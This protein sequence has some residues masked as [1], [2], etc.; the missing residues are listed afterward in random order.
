MLSGFSVTT[1]GWRSL[2]GACVSC[3][4]PFMLPG[5]LHLHCL[6][7]LSLENFDLVCDWSLVMYRGCVEFIGSRT[8]APLFQGFGSK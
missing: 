5:L 3:H 4:R 7:L 2:E 6:E 1:A 8:L